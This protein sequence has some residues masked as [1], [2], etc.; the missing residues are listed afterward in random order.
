MTGRTGVGEVYADVTIVGPSGRQRLRLLVDTGS[1]YSWIRRSLLRKLGIAK[2]DSYSFS[3]IEKKRDL[4]RRVGEARMEYRGAGR[5][6][7]IVFGR[8]EDDEVLGLHALEGLGLEV[9]PVNRRLRKR[10]RLLA[11]HT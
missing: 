11:L 3:T 7:V 5:T 8:E 1:T 10:R 9:D 4:R 2:V 6:T